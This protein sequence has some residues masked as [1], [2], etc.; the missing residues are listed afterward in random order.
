MPAHACRM[1]KGLRAMAT[2]PKPSVATTVRPICSVPVMATPKSRPSRSRKSRSR[3]PPPISPT[4]PACRACSTVSALIR[5]PTTAIL[6]ATS[7]PSGP[8]RA[9]GASTAKCSAPQHS[10]PTPKMPW[11][12]APHAA[13]RTPSAAKTSSTT[14]ST[15]ASTSTGLGAWRKITCPVTG[16]MLSTV[17]RT[18]DS[19]VV[20]NHRIN[21]LVA[22]SGSPASTRSPSFL[23]M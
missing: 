13:T 15:Y 2:R 20:L 4:A 6:P 16:E 18:G 19:M 3:R 10:P 8:T 23:S 9:S 21:G 22:A 12:Y 11:I 7:G 1:S 14:P 17:P 5:L